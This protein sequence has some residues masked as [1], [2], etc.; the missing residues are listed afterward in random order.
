MG[1]KHLVVGFI[2]GIFVGV[3]SA[4]TLEIGKIVFTKNG[5]ITYLNQAC[6]N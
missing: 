2:M 3:V 5:M 4:S 1:M 6:E